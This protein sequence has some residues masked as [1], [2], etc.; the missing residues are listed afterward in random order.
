MPPAV[1]T[2]KTKKLGKK[3]KAPALPNSK[4]TGVSEP[5]KKPQEHTTKISKKKSDKASRKPSSSA[6]SGKV[7]EIVNPLV[8]NYWNGRGLMEAPRMMLGKHVSS[9]SPKILPTHFAAFAGKFPFDGGYIDA[10]HSRP[11][12]DN[13]LDANL[14][15]FPLIQTSHGTSIGQSSA[16]NFYIASMCGLLGKN[17]TE[18][19]CVLS[20]SSH[21]QVRKDLVSNSPAAS[22]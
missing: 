16:I 22:C 5:K 1:G 12:A 14:G 3:G 8:L 18:T 9:C 4:R 13:S 10:R 2:S 17:A 11:P 21:I 15:R 6:V 19:A 7:A 20:F